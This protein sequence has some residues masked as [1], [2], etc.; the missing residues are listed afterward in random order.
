MCGFALALWTV[1]VRLFGLVAPPAG[2]AAL[3]TVLLLGFGF[4]MTFLGILGEY[5]WRTFDE[6]RGRPRYII[7]AAVNLP[8]ADKTTESPGTPGR[9]AER[10][11]ARAEMCESFVG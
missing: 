1:V 8:G 6:V 4:V 11:D 2:Y 7:E 9:G 5:L 10:S 3:M